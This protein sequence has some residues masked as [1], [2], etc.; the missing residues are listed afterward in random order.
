MGESKMRK[1]IALGIMLLFLGMTISSSTGIYLEKQNVKP[2]SKGNTLYVG[3][4]GPGNYTRIQDAIDDAS[5]GYTIYVFNGIYYE[6]LLIDKSIDLIGEDKTSTA[7]DGGGGSRIITITC[8]SVEIIG[9]TLKNS[10][11]SGFAEAIRIFDETSAIENITV[12]DCII[13]KCGKG[14]FGVDISFLTIKNCQIFDNLGACVYIEDSDH[15]IINSCEIHDN[16]EVL[17]DG[18]FRSGGITISGYEKYCLNITIFDCD[19]HDNIGMG[20]DIIQTKNVEI[21]NNDAIDNTWMGVSFMYVSNLEIH[22]NNI[23][24][25]IRQG[26]F[27]EGNNDVIVHDNV[28]SENGDLQTSDSGLLLASCSGSVAINNNTIFSNHAVGIH[29]GN[30]SSSDISNNEI[31]SNSQSGIKLRSK[32]NNN[33]ISNNSLNSNDVGITLDTASYNQIFDN[34]ISSNSFSGIRV[35]SNS[36]DNIILNNTL[37]D[38]RYGIYLSHSNNHVI[39]CNIIESNSFDGVRIDSSENNIVSNNIITKNSIEGI[40]LHSAKANIISY[41]NITQNEAHGISA[42]NNCFDNLIYHNNFINYNNAVDDGSNRWDSDYPSGGNYWFDYTGV[43]NDGDG[44]GDTPYNIS[45]GDNQDRYPFMNL[46]GWYNNTPQGP[47]LECVGSFRWSSVKPGSVLTS[48]IYVKN[49][50]ESSSELDWEIIEYPEWGTWTFTPS[51]GE[52]LTP[53]DGIKTVE[54]TIVVPEINEQKFI[55]NVKIINEQNNEDFCNLQVTLTTPRN[56]ASSPHSLLGKIVNLH[57]L[58]IK[59]N[60]NLF[61]SVSVIPSTGTTDVK[62]ITMTTSKGDT[63]YVGGSGL[64]N[65]TKIQDAI[66]NASDGDTVY[67]YNDSSPYI[68]DVIVDKSINLM[69]EDRNSTCINGWNIGDVV[70]V[71]ADWVNI[72]GFRIRNC[73]DGFQY[74]GVKIVSNNNNVYDNEFLKNF[75]PHIILEHSSF[76]TIQNNVLLDADCYQISLRNSSYN[77]IQENILSQPDFQWCVDGIGLIESSSNNLIRNNTITNLNFTVGI[78]LYDSSNNNTIQ[79]NIIC[80]NEVPDSNMIQISDSN[81]NTIIDNTLKR[82]EKGTGIALFFS[83]DNEIL[84]NT[85]E[86]VCDEGIGI[87]ACNHTLVKNNNIISSNGIGISVGISSYLNTIESNNIVNNGMGIRLRDLRIDPHIIGDCRLNKIRFNNFIGNERMAYDN[88]L[89]ALNTWYGNYWNRPRVLPK[90][91][92]GIRAIG[93]NI[94]IPVIHFDWHP[95]SEPYDIGV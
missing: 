67:V 86:S 50:G 85:I 93:D 54:V 37:S 27:I 3:G 31:K 53:E 74:A 76:N 24:K 39:S 81:S 42:D 69:G 82:N 22:N 41:N 15:I 43:D 1:I 62:Q 19:I 88:E 35:H 52:N 91:I 16:G 55:G 33:I 84:R 75:G 20:I 10:E 8:S 63:L 89:F 7:I 71:I 26:I 12:S 94:K 25:N 44:I 73:G 38:N 21:Y 49:I 32:C 72:S 40:R 29:M 90:A 34:T 59:H 4:S 46:S 56:K 64:G 60:A 83:S 47:D 14:I 2:L 6:N 13:R 61:I 58:I 65:Y 87:V 92:F 51:N 57:Y 23:K 5:D 11:Q 18:Y 9:F 70:Y 36:N 30:V 45:D 17:D 79:G 28:I 77:I 95:A 68:E 78:N 48:K 66:D 80:D